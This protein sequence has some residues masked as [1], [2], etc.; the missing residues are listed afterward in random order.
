MKKKIVSLIPVL[1]LLFAGMFWMVACEEEE[2]YP[3]TRLFMPVLNEE[4]SAEQ[5]NILVNMARMKEAVSY[6]LEIS[7]DTFKTIDYTVTVD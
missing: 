3:R 6:K 4:L 7:R 1:L 5:N 2:V